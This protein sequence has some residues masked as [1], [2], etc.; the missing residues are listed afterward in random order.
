MDS[1]IDPV[2]LMIAVVCSFGIA[3]M[4]QRAALS[5]IL[6]AMSRGSDSERS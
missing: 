3:F 1:L 2:I 6:K 5:L 4:A